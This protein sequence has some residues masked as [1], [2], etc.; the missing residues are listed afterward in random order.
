MAFQVAG[1]TIFHGGP[2]QHVRGRY[3][4]LFVVSA[5]SGLVGALLGVGDNPIHIQCATHNVDD[6]RLTASFADCIWFTSF[7]YA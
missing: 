2:K 1:R 6:M 5:E 3:I 7:V 4:T